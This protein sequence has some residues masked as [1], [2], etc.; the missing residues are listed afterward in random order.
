MGQ[1]VSHRVFSAVVFHVIF[2][3][4]VA[5]I[6]YIISLPAQACVLQAVVCVRAPAHPRPPFLGV[7]LLQDRDRLITPP[8]QTFEHIPYAPQALNPPCTITKG[9]R[10]RSRI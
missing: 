1:R 8:P 5:K 3:I 6:I 2:R 7:G 4:Y 9:L 10:I